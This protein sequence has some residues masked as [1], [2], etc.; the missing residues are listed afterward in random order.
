M[1]I[2]AGLT[3][4]LVYFLPSTS[5]SRPTTQ[6]QT[7]QGRPAARSESPRPQKDRTAIPEIKGCTRDQT[8]FY[9]GKVLLFRRTPKAIEITISTDWDTTEKLVQSTK[10]N[11]VEYR[12]QNRPIEASEFQQLESRLKHHTDDVRATVWVCQV[13]TLQSVKIIDWELPD[14]KLTR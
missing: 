4:A 6:P 1:N 11:P 10:T 13:K 12:L 8:T 9:Q 14:S 2:F 7:E 3:I 5:C